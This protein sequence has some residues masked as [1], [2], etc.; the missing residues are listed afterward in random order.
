M[1][2]AEWK[3]KHQTPATPEQLARMEASLALNAKLRG[4]A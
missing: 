4:E 3:A 1:P 2:A